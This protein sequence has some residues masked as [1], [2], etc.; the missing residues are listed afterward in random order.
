MTNNELKF[1]DPETGAELHRVPQ[2][3]KIPADMPYG[4]IDRGEHV[5]RYWR[6]RGTPWGLTQE[7]SVLRFTR[8]PIAPPK[9]P[10]PPTEPGSL[11]RAVNIG[12]DKCATMIRLEDGDWHGV[13]QDGDYRFW[14][15]ES[16]TSWEPMTA[17]PTETLDRLRVLDPEDRR[18]RVD[19]EG[20]VWRYNKDFNGWESGNE[21]RY[22]YLEVVYN[23]FGPLCFADEGSCDERY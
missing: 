18:D 20:Y 8:E 14:V 3:A 22:Y 15:D 12:G 10:K 9:P 2:G 16:I 17:V 23:N 21:V 6:S 11:I 13:D 4:I 1:Y 19:A 5:E 7:D